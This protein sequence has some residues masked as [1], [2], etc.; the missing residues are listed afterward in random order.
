[1]LRCFDDTVLY[2]KVASKTNS[3]A[4][5][6]VRL[7]SPPSDVAMLFSSLLTYSW[8]IDRYTTLEMSLISLHLE[9]AGCF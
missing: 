7:V 6:K 5:R 9:M 4:T 2:F 8:M 3:V 1:M